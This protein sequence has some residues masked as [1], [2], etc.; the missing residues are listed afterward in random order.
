MRASC[1]AHCRRGSK[2]A[3]GLQQLCVSYIHLCRNYSA[4][5]GVYG[6]AP[7]PDT[8]ARVH[9]VERDASSR[10]RAV[11]TT[12]S[13]SLGRRLPPRQRQDMGADTRRR[14]RLRRGHRILPRQKHQLRL[15]APPQVNKRRRH[16]AVQRYMPRGGRCNSAGCTRR[17]LAPAKRDDLQPLGE[18][19]LS[20]VAFYALMECRACPRQIACEV[21]IE[22][23]G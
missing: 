2:N 13:S 14:Y 19:D 18:H 6:N 16:R 20:P 7:Q 12:R 3:Q 21:F 15:T 1:A 4:I 9:I 23:S 5:V 10:Y 11:E 17:R 8:G 22:T